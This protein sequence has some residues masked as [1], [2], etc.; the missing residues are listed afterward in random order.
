MMTQVKRV[1]VV[2]AVLALCV[3]LNGCLVVGYSS[4]GGWWMWPGSIVITLVLLL[5]FL[6]SRR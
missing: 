6:M 2:V 5:L 1:G 4:G 3:P